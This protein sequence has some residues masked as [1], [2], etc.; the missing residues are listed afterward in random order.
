M[1]VI[2]NSGL[3]ITNYYYLK[4]IIIVRMLLRNTTLSLCLLLCILLNTFKLKGFITALNV[5][6]TFRNNSHKYHINSIFSLTNKH[7]YLYS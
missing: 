6:V 4:S 3:L 5:Q 7:K 1:N 2:N